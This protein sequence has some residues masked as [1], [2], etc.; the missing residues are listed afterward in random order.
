MFIS[1]YVRRFIYIYFCS[2]WPYIHKGMG[3]IVGGRGKV[4]VSSVK[5]VYC[6]MCVGPYYKC[7]S[8]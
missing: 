4:T 5:C 6:V 7:L 3:P 1:N 2:L 8:K